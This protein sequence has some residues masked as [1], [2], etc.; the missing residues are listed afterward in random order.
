MTEPFGSAAWL[1]HA[2]RRS[3]YVALTG[4]YP[5]IDVESMRSTALDLIILGNSLSQPLASN[6][7]R[8]QRQCSGDPLRFAA[9]GEPGIG[10]LGKPSY[11]MGDWQ[12]DNIWVEQQTFF[13]VGQHASGGDVLVDRACTPEC[14][15][16]GLKLETAS[17][18]VERYFRLGF[19][20]SPGLA[21]E[22]LACPF[23][24]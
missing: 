4:F 3:N 18:S 12:F 1:H 22:C 24:E 20:F 17:K 21:H 7:L 9:C 19:L 11:E 23:Q 15:S 5:I 16:A 8:R 10:W 2:N 13:L 14:Q 6:G